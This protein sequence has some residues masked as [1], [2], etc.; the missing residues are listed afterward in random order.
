MNIAGYV[1]QTPGRVDPDSAFAQ[2]E[3]IR[4]WVRDTGDELIAICQ[5]HHGSTAP[6][7]RPGFRALLDII[8]SNGADAVVVGSLD[9]LSPDI[10]TQEIM[11]VDLRAAGASVIATEDHD[12]EILREGGGDHARMI[13]R[14]VVAKVHEYSDAY[15]LSGV[16]EPTV[17]AAVLDDAPIEPPESTNVVIELI[18]PTG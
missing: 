17:T 7:E 8:R 18:A 3:R 2:S 16:T 11:L 1:R 9:A 10:I 12:C 6:S 14:D 4:R 13:V 15:G 5:D